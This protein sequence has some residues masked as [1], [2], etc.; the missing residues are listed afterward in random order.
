MMAILVGKS[1]KLKLNKEAKYLIDQK[2]IHALREKM[3]EMVGGME[4]STR[5][6]WLLLSKLSPY[7]S[8]KMAVQNI[9][10]VTQHSEKLSQKLSFLQG[11]SEEDSEHHL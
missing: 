5:W 4:V 7:A 8:Q 3:Y 6:G 2:V 1:K 9:Q 11:T 10:A